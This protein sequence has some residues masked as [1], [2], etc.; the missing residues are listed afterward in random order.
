MDLLRPYLHSC[1][2]ANFS[3][4]KSKF[5]LHSWWLWIVGYLLLASVISWEMTSSCSLAN[6]I[7]SP[8]QY[9]EQWS[10]SKPAYTFFK[11]TIWCTHALAIVSSYPFRSCQTCHFP[12]V[13]LIV[14][15]DIRIIFF[16]VQ[17]LHIW[18]LSWFFASCAIQHACLGTLGHWVGENYGISPSLIL[19]VPSCNNKC[20]S[21]SDNCFL[22]GLQSSVSC[23]ESCIWMLHWL[24]WSYIL[25]DC[26]WNKSEWC[27]VAKVRRCIHWS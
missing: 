18:S 17:V 15:P 22:G 2:V 20:N 13:Y 26:H 16:S 24:F 6:I 5:Y 23:S 11:W 8:L 7:S 27:A 14:R 1:S 3:F 9:S 10:S 4:V 25:N 12:L 19:D 21:S